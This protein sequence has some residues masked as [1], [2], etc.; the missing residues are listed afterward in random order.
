MEKMTSVRCPIC[1]QRIVSTEE[2]DLSTRLRYHLSDQHD[3]RENSARFTSSLASVGGS[4]SGR[5][6][7]TTTVRTGS[8]FRGAEH[9]REEQTWAP[10]EGTAIPSRPKGVGDWMR[11]ALGTNEE[12][13]GK[14]EWTRGEGYPAMM[15][16]AADRSTAPGHQMAGPVERSEGLVECPMCGRPVTG[17]DESEL[18]QALEEHFRI[19]HQMVP[20]MVTR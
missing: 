10:E 9:R 20:K 5:A 14:E 1:E 2:E 6:V 12:A 13:G 3:M 19:Q 7:E 18:S 4:A 11:K 8:G 17:S 16:R 15:E